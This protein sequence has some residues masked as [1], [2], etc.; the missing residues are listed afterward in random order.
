MGFRRVEKQ[1]LVQP[2]VPIN[3]ILILNINTQNLIS[4]SSIGHKIQ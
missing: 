3:S 1:R 4:G 2:F